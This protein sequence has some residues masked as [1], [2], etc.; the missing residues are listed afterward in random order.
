MSVHP[1]T[2]GAD[3]LGMNL[4]PA[5]CPLAKKVGTNNQQQAASRQ[6]HDVMTAMK[7]DLRDIC[8]QQKTCSRNRV[9]QKKEISGLSQKKEKRAAVRAGAQTARGEERSGA[10]EMCA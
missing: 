4:H 8:M 2:L 6:L 7:E 10:G 3:T 9:R 1:P 5:G